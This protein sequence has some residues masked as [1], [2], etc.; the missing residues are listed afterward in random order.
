M[1]HFGIEKTWEGIRAFTPKC[2]D[3]TKTTFRHTLISFSYLVKN[4]EQLSIEQFRDRIRKHCADSPR[5]LEILKA[6][7]SLIL[8]EK[9]A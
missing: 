2:D 1:T 8:L 9:Q 6:L 3:E 4:G 5:I 7:D